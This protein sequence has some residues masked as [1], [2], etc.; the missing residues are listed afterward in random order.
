M[1]WLK[2]WRFL[3][4][5]LA[6]IM[7]LVVYPVLSGFA[8]TRLLLDVLLTLVFV[9]GL[10]T[11][12]AQRRLRVVALLLAIPTLAGL[13][14]G[15][16]I[17]GMPR[18]KMGIGFHICAVL[19]LTFVIGVTFQAVH[20]EERV[21]AD[22]INGAFCGYLLA[23]L[24]FGH[25]YCLLE[26]LAPGSFLGNG[27]FAAQVANSDHRHFVL[28]YFSFVTLT[29]V[30]YGDI[31][32]ASAPSRAWAVVEAIVGQFYIAVLVAELI[33]KRVAQVLSNRGAGG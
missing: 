27:E 25:I 30:G 31:T 24:A 23:G 1:T 5:M 9:G 33:G 4:L 7:L 32:P 18:E 15:Y 20:K 14:T 6:L 22:A 21:T 28:T 19:F 11:I 3:G 26:I 16:V 17:P 8:W 2:R 12:I 10:L 29:T 13:W